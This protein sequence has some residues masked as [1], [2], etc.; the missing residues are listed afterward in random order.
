MNSDYLRP[1]D[2]GL[3]MRDSGDY[4]KDKLKILEAYIH[5]FIVAM[6]GKQWR[7]INYIDLQAGP[8]KNI[9]RGSGDIMLGSPLIA[10]QAKKHFDNYWFVEMGDEEFQALET[11]VLVSDRAS[12]V[13]LL[14]GDCNVKIDTI[15]ARLDAIDKEYIEGWWPSLNLAFLDPEGLEINWSTVEKLGRI[16]RM[17]LMLNFSTS[18]FTRN[19]DLQF[20][21]EETRLDSFFGTPEWREVYEPVR[22]KDNSVVRRTMI[23]FYRERLNQLGYVNQ[24]VREKVFKNRRNVQIYTLIFASKHKLGNKFWNQAIDDNRPRLL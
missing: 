4:A 15:I 14:H 7:A 9:F 10:L 24:Q 21:K 20:E 19:A 17:D 1:V 23:D 11:R 6:R 12:D 18:G 13:H 5:R 22:S 8:G 3:P 16:S 2:D